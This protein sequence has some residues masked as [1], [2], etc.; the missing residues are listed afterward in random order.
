MNKPI[1]Y[2]STYEAQSIANRGSKGEPVLISTSRSTLLRTR[3]SSVASPA[4]SPVDRRVM[5]TIHSSKLNTTRT[6][7]RRVL[8]R[9]SSRQGQPCLVRGA[10]PSLD[11]AVRASL[12]RCCLHGC[13]HSP[14]STAPSPPGR[15]G[16]PSSSS[17][18]TIRRARFE[19]H[20]NER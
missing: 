12:G 10:C 3:S 20:T 13:C 7:T 18:L 19:T 15:S 4:T 8:P 6:C 14:S 17:V 1:I 9:D 11:R 5:L 16:R 2:V